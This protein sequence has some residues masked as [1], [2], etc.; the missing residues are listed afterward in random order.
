VIV[1]VRDEP[2]SKSGPAPSPSRGAGAAVLE[3]MQDDLAQIERDLA[4]TRNEIARLEQ[5]EVP[6]PEMP[7]SGSEDR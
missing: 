2:N 4:E 5:L 7:A 3:R 6:D 1:L